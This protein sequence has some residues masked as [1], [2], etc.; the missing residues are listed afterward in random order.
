MAK[1]PRRNPQDTTL[2]NARAANK[3]LD[4]IAQSIAELDQVLSTRL[5]DINTRIVVLVDLVEQIG[6]HMLGE[7]KEEV[8][9]GPANPV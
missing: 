9:D 4:A 6:Q 8:S 2:R 5:T 1:R 3:R 7:K